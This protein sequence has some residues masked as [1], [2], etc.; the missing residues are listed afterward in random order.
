MVGS[1]SQARNTAQES[2]HDN[3]VA[4]GSLGVTQIFLLRPDLLGPGLQI[5]SCILPE[6]LT[7]KQLTCRGKLS[8][9]LGAGRRTIVR[10]QQQPYCTSRRDLIRPTQK[11]PGCRTIFMLLL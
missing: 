11:Q 10:C 2:S 6:G 1:A 7:E 9:E 8:L 5:D 4:S 3:Q